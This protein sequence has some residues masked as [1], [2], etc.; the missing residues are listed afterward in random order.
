MENPKE[1]PTWKNE[2]LPIGNTELT[3][4][5][6]SP[7]GARGRGA[8]RALAASGP[9][10]PGEETEARVQNILGF[11]STP[12]TLGSFVFSLENITSTEDFP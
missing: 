7:V 6:A 11:T 3:E 1:L 4:L 8:H 2:H 10:P 5:T 12:S 9:G